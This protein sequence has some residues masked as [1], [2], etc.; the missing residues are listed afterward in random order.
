MNTQTEPAL[1]GMTD[2]ELARLAELAQV[3]GAARDALSDDMVARLAGTASEGMNLLDR[4]TRNEGL[5]RLLQVLDE[6]E[7]QQLLVGLSE[8]IHKTSRD[9]APT[10]PAVGGLACMLR[11]VRDPGAQEGLRLLAIVGNHLSRSLREQHRHGG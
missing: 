10:P 1:Q 8:A 2:E 11:I 7:S 4:L 3:V 9:V 5:M 6:E